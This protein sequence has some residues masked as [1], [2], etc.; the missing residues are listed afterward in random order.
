MSRNAQEGNS[1][2]TQIAIAHL[3]MVC[4]AAAGEIVLDAED[5]KEREA[6]LMKFLATG[7][8]GVTEQAQAEA[9]AVRAALGEKRAA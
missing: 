6:W 3:S 4:Q 7:E 8:G 2:M 1:I 9:E 5:L